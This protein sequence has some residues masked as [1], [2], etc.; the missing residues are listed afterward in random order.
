MNANHRPLPSASVVIPT[1]DRPEDLERTVST[2]LL[3]SLLP[4]ELIVV[5][6]SGGTETERRVQCQL[7]QAPLAVR[8]AVQ[9]HYIKDPSI[10]S[11]PEAR[12]RAMET[13]RGEVWLFLDDDVLLESDFLEQLLKAYVAAPELTGASGVITNYLPPPL[14]FRMW[15]NLF[16]RGPF[17]DDRQ[18]IYWTAERLRG[19]NPIPVTCLTGA[20]MSFRA[21]AIR[22]LRFD[23][24]MR[25]VS[26]GEDVDFCCRLPAGARLV[27]CPRARLAHMKSPRGRAGDHAL[28]RMVLGTHFLYRKNWRRGIVNRFWF[29]WLNVGCALLATLASVHRR[30][31]EPWHAFLAGI[32]KAKIPVGRR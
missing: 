10:K 25:G 1:K 5:D 22:G 17:H 23:E 26:E 2:L 21:S 28:H 32:A 30:S 18:S 24:N 9:L 3:Q 11:L 16:R 29:L 20:L 31:L 7:L 8:Q 4:R 13:A 14:W 6:Q 27:I 15:T 12:N 19:A